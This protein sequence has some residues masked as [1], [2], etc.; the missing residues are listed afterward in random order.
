MKYQSPIAPY[1]QWMANLPEDELFSDS[2]PFLEG[3]EAGYNAAKRTGDEAL[4]ELV[5][6]LQ[7]I[8][9]EEEALAENDD[10]G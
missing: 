10:G 5:G 7:Q 2:L 3:R 6:A 4:K 1:Y 9:D 8:R